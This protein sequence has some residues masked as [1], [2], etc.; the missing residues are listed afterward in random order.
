LKFDP[1]SRRFALDQMAA[2]R[3]NRSRGGL[4]LDVDAFVRAEMKARQRQVED[5]FNYPSKN[6]WRAIELA[7]MSLLEYMFDPNN[8]D[9][10]AREY[11]DPRY[12]P[13]PLTPCPKCTG[14]HCVSPILLMISWFLLA[15]EV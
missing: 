15:D 6:L 1:P 11:A 12:P 9:I 2:W 10:F 7:N 3:E 14:Q 5:L 13:A 4:P 8:Y